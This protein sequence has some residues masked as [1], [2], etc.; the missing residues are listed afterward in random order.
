MSCSNE[1]IR[2]EIA[3]GTKIGEARKTDPGQL[4]PDSLG[5]TPYLESESTLPPIYTNG[6]SVSSGVLYIP[7]M[8][9]FDTLIASLM[10]HNDSVLNVWEDGLGFTSLRRANY[11]LE[12]DETVDDL[13]LSMTRIP[14]ISFETV[15]NTENK[16]RIED[17]LYQVDILNSKVYTINLNNSERDTLDFARSSSSCVECNY[18]KVTYCDEL[19]NDGSKVEGKKWNQFYGFYMSFGTRSTFYKKNSNGKWKRTKA[20]EIFLWL[21][22][23][24]DTRWNYRWIVDGTCPNVPWNYIPSNETKRF[25]KRENAKTVARTFQFF[26][27]SGIKDAMM[28]YQEFCVNKFGRVHH[29][30]VNFYDD[31]HNENW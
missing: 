13:L 21:D 10:N 27:G 5:L 2:D 4:S 1:R 28:R 9:T 23:Y 16:I 30:T 22:H 8:L 7:D 25:K 17:T 15:L 18:G 3:N 12:Q 31:C 11:N 6:I 29:W 26:A 14:D 20:D 19:Q 24:N